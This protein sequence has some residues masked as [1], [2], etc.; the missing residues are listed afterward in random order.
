VNVVDSSGWLEY[1]T[2]G[3]KADFFALPIE[4]EANLITPTICMYEVFKRV[5]QVIGE[6]RAVEAMGVKF[7]DGIVELNRQTAIEAARL[8][9]RNKLSMADSINLATAQAYDATLWTMD[10]HFKDIEGVR[11]IEKKP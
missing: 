2:D 1:L 9:I 3:A 10:A 8:S 6:E 5:L 7:R 4:D 11:Y